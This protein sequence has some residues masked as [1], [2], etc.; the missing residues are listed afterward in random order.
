MKISSWIDQY[1]PLDLAVG[2]PNIETAEFIKNALIN[3]QNLHSN[4]NQYTRSKVFKIKFNY[5]YI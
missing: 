5:N 4:I 2:K 1:T 3:T